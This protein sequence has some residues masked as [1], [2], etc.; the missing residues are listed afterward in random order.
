MDSWLT[1]LR[2][3]CS[4]GLMPGPR[5]ASLL[6]RERRCRAAR[7]LRG[8][9][10]MTQSHHLLWTVGCQM[11]LPTRPANA[12]LPFSNHEIQLLFSKSLLLILQ[13]FL[14]LPGLNIC[15]FTCSVI[16]QDFGIFKKHLPF[17]MVA[18]EDFFDSMKWAM[19]KK[20]SSSMYGPRGKENLIYSHVQ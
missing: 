14:V 7:G 15:L 20:P 10:G 2:S 12:T 9:A 17:S 5:S 8:A 3:I 18:T 6:D 13:N 19:L 4:S 1:E 16:S 11:F